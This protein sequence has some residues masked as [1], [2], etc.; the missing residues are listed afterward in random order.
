MP[1]AAARELG[2]RLA[3]VALC[4]TAADRSVLP[5]PSLGGHLRD[6]MI[7]VYTRDGVP[8]PEWTV[9][10]VRSGTPALS[11]AQC[12]VLFLR[13]A[14]DAPEA[15]PDRFCLRGGTLFRWRDAEAQWEISRPVG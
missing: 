8:Q 5:P 11:E 2:W 13:R 9:D 12:V 4:A 15:A 6:G 7:L 3:T 14:P 1:L 10:S